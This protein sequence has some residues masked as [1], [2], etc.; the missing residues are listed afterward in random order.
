MNEHEIRIDAALGQL[1]KTIDEPWESL[2]WTLE[3]Y[4]PETIGDSS[5][6]GS[7]AWHLMHIA[8]VFRIH[9]KAFM[10]ADAVGQ[11]PKMP[12]DVAGAGKMVREDAHRFAAWCKANP[13]RVG[14][15]V[16][17]QEQSFEEMMGVMLRHI[18]WHAAAVHYWFVWFRAGDGA[19]VE[20]D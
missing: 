12:S 14:R 5:Q 4:P 11:W 20:Q 7:A 2:G 1:L 6:T 15:V 19:R 13:N 3:K 16:H 10:G 18:V 17:G 8:E 9:A